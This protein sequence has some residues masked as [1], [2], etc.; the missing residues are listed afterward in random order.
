MKV[1]TPVSLD[2]LNIATLSLNV[3]QINLNNA[4]VSLFTVKNDE[5]WPH[6]SVKKSTVCSLHFTPGQ[7]SSFTARLQNTRPTFWSS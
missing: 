4:P 7:Q 3:T 6:D 5:K 2:I 1:C